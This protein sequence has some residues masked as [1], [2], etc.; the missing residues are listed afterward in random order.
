MMFNIQTKNAIHPTGLSLFNQKHYSI[1]AGEPV[2]AMVVR[3]ENLH[4][5]LIP[6]SLLVVGRAGAGVNNIPLETF[7]KAGIPVLN[8]PG[9]NAN[10]VKELVLGSLFIANRNLPQAWQYIELEGPKQNDLKPFVEACKK[11]FVGQELPGKTLVIIGLGAVGCLVANDALKLGLKVIGFDPGITVHH[12]WQLDSHITQAHSIE[13]AIRQ[14]DFMSIHVPL[15]PKTQDLINA[16]LLSHIKTGAV[17]LN[18]SRQEVVSEEAV[19]TAL[20]DGTLNLYVTDFPSVRWFGNP[21]VIAFP[22]LG[23]STGEAEENCATMACQ[24]VIDYLEKGELTH[25]VNYPDVRLPALKSPRLAICNSNVPNIIGQI[26]SC[27][28]FAK[29]NILDMINNSKGDFAYTI[30]DLSEMPDSNVLEQL[31]AINGV[32]KVRL[33]EPPHP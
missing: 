7:A 29:L 17:L 6:E 9:A 18:F 13:E 20:A 14:A 12:A 28:G 31:H 5:M 27:L 30:V 16:N 33:C 32:L 23:A 11:Q 25:A 8:T 2:H 22:H 19:E 21:K 1:D 15:T 3:S 26:S 24:Q 10:A 4:D